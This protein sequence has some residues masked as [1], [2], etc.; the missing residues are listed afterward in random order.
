MNPRIAF[1]GAPLLTLVYGMIRLLSE[2]GPG[3]AWTTGHVAFL[4]ALGLY[5]VVLIQLDRHT[6]TGFTVVGFAGLVAFAAQFVIDVVVGFMAADRAEM[7]DLFGR[8]YDTP[9]LEVAVQQVG[10][11]LF[12][13]A[14]FAVMTH[15]AIQRRIPLWIP[16]AVL[17]ASVLPA[18][19]LDL[20]PVSALLILIAFATVV[21]GTVDLEEARP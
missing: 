7:S 9:G 16:V 21:R 17:V 4:V 14:L 6:F 11:P 19:E 3:L 2:H 1:I 18:F 20:L 5:G 10:P 15:L 8:V 12:Y 13:L